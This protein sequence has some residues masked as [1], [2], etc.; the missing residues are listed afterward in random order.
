MTRRTSAVSRGH[1]SR[2]AAT[3]SDAP[4]EG[5]AHCGLEEAG[6]SGRASGP[7]CSG[8]AST[9]A[10]STMRR[11][12]ASALLAPLLLLALLVPGAWG[13]LFGSK[14]AKAADGEVLVIDG[15]DAFNAAVQAHDFLVVEFYAPVRARLPSHRGG[16]HTTRRTAGSCQ[17]GHSLPSRTGRRACSTRCR[18]HT[19]AT[20]ECHAVRRVCRA[21][22]VCCTRGRVGQ[23]LPLM[24][25]RPLS[26][27]RPGPG[28]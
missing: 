2:C 16:P 28:P 27:P 8:A 6:L 21:G 19:G 18:P 4:L 14:G 10:Q 5:G 11:A 24:R 12:R 20:R 7:P 25:D 23:Q 26:S 13:G 9:T 17:C 22:P 3:R 1:T 15:T